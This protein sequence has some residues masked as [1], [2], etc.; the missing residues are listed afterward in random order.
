MIP[1]LFASEISTARRFDE[2]VERFDAFV[3]DAAAT[4]A[5]AASAELEAA[6]EHVR[7]LRLS[8]TGE[9]DRNLAEYRALGEGEAGVAE[10]VRELIA[11]AEQRR[12]TALA[13]DEL[14]QLDALPTFAPSPAATLGAEIARLTDEALTLEA[15]PPQHPVRLARIAEL[16]D[17]ERLAGEI[18]TVL[19]RRAE[20]ELRQPPA[21]L[22][23]CSGHTQNFAIRN[24][25]PRR[26]GYARVARP[27]HGRDSAPRLEPRSVPVWRGDRTWAEFV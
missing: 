4:A 24:A 15:Q 7:R 25:P 27:D 13:V 21:K 22:P 8:T 10:A 6:M 23:N 16:T 5:D 20:L 1:A 9:L 12:T 18:D 17:A 11:G 19:V 3:R 14:P 26:V 2:L